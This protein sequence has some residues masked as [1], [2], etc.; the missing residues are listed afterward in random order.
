[1]R[2]CIRRCPEDGAL[3]MTFVGKKIYTASRMKFM[4]DQADGKEART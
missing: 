2:E 4:R 1:M 3:Y